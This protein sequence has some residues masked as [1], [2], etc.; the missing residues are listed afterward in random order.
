MSELDRDAGH[1]G[2]QAPPPAHTVGAR[3]RRAREAA[4]LSLADIAAQTKI[5]ERHLQAIEA[6]RFADLASRTY[7]VG[8]SRSFA[9]TLGLPE[10]EIADAVR[11]QLDTSDVWDAPKA[12]VFEPGDPARVPPSRVAWLA[13]LGALAAIAVVFALWRSYYDPAVSL[14][15]L[16]SE[17]PAAEVSSAPASQ[18]AAPAATPVGGEVVFTALEAGVWVKFYDAAGQ[19]L[20]QKQMAQGERYV[21]PADA[22]G[23]MLW[24]ARP[25]ALAISVG[26]RAVPPLAAVQTTMKDVPVTAS[27]LLARQPAPAPAAAPAEALGQA[28]PRAAEPARPAPRPVRTAPVAANPAPPLSGAM[29]EPSTV[30][31]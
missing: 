10:R 4:G 25:D 2:V 27:A 26:G 19:Q 3:L 29:A 15:D 24:T 12:A 17:E 23:P 5:A 8:F 31:E 28:A 9:R 6:D 18:A 21:V 30:S 14:P 22:Q 7:A 20:M 16:T 11:A 1:D 13:G